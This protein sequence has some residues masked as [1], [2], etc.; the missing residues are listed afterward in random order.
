MVNSIISTIPVPPAPGSTVPVTIAVGPH[1]LTSAVTWGTTPP[2]PSITAAGANTSNGSNLASSPMSVRPDASDGR[3]QGGGA[4][5]CVWGS[6]GVMT[7]Y[8]TV[9]GAGPRGG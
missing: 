8:V 6:E 2:A 4:R 5:R 7:R 3:R 1:I 9:S